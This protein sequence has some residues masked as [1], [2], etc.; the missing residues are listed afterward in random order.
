MFV[1]Q[2]RPICEHGLQRRC[3]QGLHKL[4]CR[5]HLL[6]HSERSR[7]YSLFFVRSRDLPKHGLRRCGQHRLCVLFGRLNFQHDGQR[8]VLLGLPRLRERLCL[9]MH[10]DR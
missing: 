7:L 6:N 10:G 1:L 8:S 5:I 3:Q 4:P 2:R 9:D